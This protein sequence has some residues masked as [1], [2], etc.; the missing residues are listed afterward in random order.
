MCVKA[1]LTPGDHVR[2]VE[3]VRTT[4]G[5]YVDPLPPSDPAD[6]ALWNQ[7]ERLAIMAS[8]CKLH[9][10]LIYRHERKSVWD[11]WVAIEGSHV[12]QDANVRYAA[13][14]SLL[15]VRK[16]ADDNYTEYLNRAT[17]SRY[18]I[19]RVTPARVTHEERMD[20]IVLFAAVCGLPADDLMRR[21]LVAQKNVSF[22]DAK[23]AFLRVDQDSR[24]VV[25]VESAHAA[26]SGLCFT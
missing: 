21:Q 7:S 11:L 10:E 20:E 5:A 1:Y 6:L 25:A 2:V 26:A 22:L 14:M 13:W 12:Q 18:R 17:D 16:A 23:A 4:G 24:V 9:L 15:G 8:A 3:Q 19:D